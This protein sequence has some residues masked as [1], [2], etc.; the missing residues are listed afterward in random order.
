MDITYCLYAV[1]SNETLV[2][3]RGERAYLPLSKEPCDNT[4]SV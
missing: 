4:N 1:I 2:F 3:V